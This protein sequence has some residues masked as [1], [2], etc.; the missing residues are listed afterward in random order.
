MKFSLSRGVMLGVLSLTV[1]VAAQAPAEPVEAAATTQ[2]AADPIKVNA[3]LQQLLDP[4]PA[5]VNE[6][7][8]KLIAMGDAARPA[9]ELLLR[10]RQLADDILSTIETNK[11]ASAS[12]I[13]L[14]LTDASVDDILAALSKQAGYPLRMYNRNVIRRGGNNDDP[15]TYSVEYDNQPFWDVIRDVC[16]KTGISPYNDGQNRRGLTFMPAANMGGSLFNCPMYSSGA[17]LCAVQSLSRNSSINFGQNSPPSNSFNAQL[18]LMF[19]PKV[20]INSYYYQPIIEEA[21][22]DRGNDLVLKNQGSSGTNSSSRQS[23]INLNMSLKYPTANPGSKI[24]KLRGK[25][26]LNVAT[27]SEIIE[28]TDLT[29]E[30]TKKS[31]S[32]RRF[33]IKSVKPQSENENNRQWNVA[34][35]FHRDGME[36]QKWHEML[37]NPS[38]R[39]IDG[40]GRDLRYQHNS[41]SDSNDQEA[42]QTLV[43]YRYGRNE[44][45]DEDVNEPTT[46]IWEVTTDTKEITIP[47]EFTDLPMP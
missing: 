9:L 35:T 43:F 4:D 31:P 11:V 44:G 30:Q 45:N 25:A 39:L 32:G 29:K 21:V 13:T 22:D 15:Q 26:R 24:V 38:I 46:V 17:A 37:N 7:R 41:R 14:K 18:A 6:A 33:T 3:L 10:Q 16:N 23:Q 34:V 42:N 47:F 8:T 12:M 20:R 40:A 2:P 28:I 1:P 36:Q 19:E 27:R 5:K